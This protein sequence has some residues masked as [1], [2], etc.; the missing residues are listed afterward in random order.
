MTDYINVNLKQQSNS[1]KN[2]HIY[3]MIKDELIIY[4]NLI[5]ILIGFSLLYFLNE[6]T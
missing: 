5:C 4:K 2:N 1:F 3:H 6:S